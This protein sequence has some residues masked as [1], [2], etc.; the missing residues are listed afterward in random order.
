MSNYEDC[1]RDERQ[2]WVQSVG[3]KIAFRG[4]ALDWFLVL[5][6]C[7]EPESIDSLG[8]D[9]NMPEVPAAH[10]GLGGRWVFF[11]VFIPASLNKWAQRASRNLHEGTSPVLVSGPGREFR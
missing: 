3:A 9:H 4:Q 6:S 1:V 11:C 7:P 10:L 5:P 2:L 8:L